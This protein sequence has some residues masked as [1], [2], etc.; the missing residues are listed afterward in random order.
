MSADVFGEEEE[1]QL[2]NQGNSQKKAKQDKARTTWLAE[3]IAA[4]KYPFSPLPSWPMTF[5]ASGV[6]PNPFVTS[7]TMGMLAV[8]PWMASPVWAAA[9]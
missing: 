6:S 4:P 7:P 1:I 3:S 2:R 5:C 8:V 9:D